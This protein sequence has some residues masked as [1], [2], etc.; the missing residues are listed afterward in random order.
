MITVTKETGYEFNIF[1]EI[2]HTFSNEAAKS[3]RT[4]SMKNQNYISS[5]ASGT[6]ETNQLDRTKRNS[7]EGINNA[8]FNTSVNSKKLEPSEENTFSETT[9][10]NDSCYQ[11]N[12]KKRVY[13]RKELSKIGDCTVFTYADNHKK[14]Q[15]V[16]NSRNVSN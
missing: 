12:T 10:K 9:K 14:S 15:S 2:N 4:K 8:Q 11:D 3:N 13:M 16:N 5:K 6:L 1:E 7:S